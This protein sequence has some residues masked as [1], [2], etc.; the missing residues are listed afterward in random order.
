VIEWHKHSAESA[1]ENLGVSPL[2]GLSRDEAEERAGRYGLNEL[3]ERRLKSPWTILWE[4]L[5]STMDLILIFAAVVSFALGEWT[6]A[7]AILAIVAVN[8]LLGLR[9]EYKAEK[10]MAALKKMAVPTVRVRRSGSIQLISSRLL[11]PG[12][13]VLLDGGAR[14]PA[15]GRLIEAANLLVEEAALTGESLAVEKSATWLSERDVVL[16]DRINMVFMGTSVNQGRAVMLVTATGMQTE[17]GKIAEM[18]QGVDRSA[19]PLQLRLDRLGKVLAVAALLLVAVIFGLGLWREGTAH[20]R[21]LFLTAVSMAVAAVPEG[22][23]AVVTIA[24]ALG[25]Q[26]ML[27]RH[28]LV[29]K[30]LAVEALGSVSV[31]CSDKTG[32]LTENR[33]VVRTLIAGGTRYETPLPGGAEIPP[34]LF[35]ALMAG[36]L[37]NDAEVSID[38][39]TRTIHGDPTENALLNVAEEAGIRKAEWEGRWPRVAEI[40][41]DS[42]R[43][44]MTTLHRVGDAPTPAST[45]VA[46]S[47]PWLSF[48]KG[49]VDGLLTVCDRILLNGEVLPLDNEAAARVAD[50]NDL[51]AREGLRVLGFACAPWPDP[52]ENADAKRLEKGLVFIG[53]MALHDPPRREVKD[54]VA[55][56]RSAGIR[57]VMITGDHPLTA[58]HIASELG[59]LTHDG[60]V[61]TGNQLDEMDTAERNRTLVSATVFARVSPETKLAIVSALQAE[62]QIVAMTGDGV[63]DAPALKRANIGVAMGITGT[64]VSKEA[65]DIVLLDDNFATI[66]ATV[67]EGRTIYDNIRKFIKYLMTTNSAELWVML[68]APFL[69]MPLPLLPLQILWM[70]LVTDGL[71]ALALGVEPPERDVMRRPPV[72]AKESIFAGGTGFHILWVGL[73]MGLVSLALGWF[74]WRLEGMEG[75]EETR[76]QTMVF[77]ILTLSQMAHVL[78]IRTGMDSLFRVGLW[79]NR[80]LILAV[81]ATFAFQLILLYTPFFQQIFGLVPLTVVDLLVALV[82]GAVVF[83]AVEAEK[84]FYRSRRGIS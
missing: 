18:I 16:A 25:A 20:L 74:Y 9:Q 83:F 10:A 76:W 66:V 65:S 58:R 47:A 68:T 38:G 72:G 70:N 64:D 56:C 67:A 48:T 23:P 12:D 35:L 77:T 45:L 80:P 26:R 1:L 15:D 75:S 36:S 13:L 82:S 71:P 44:R 31:I 33:M 50:H 46:G 4:Q 60:Q 2:Q 73:L 7:F 37:C 84:W 3:N 21:E 32:T 19:T 63:N 57:P 51:L 49:A 29:R 62:G 34:E 17:L 55:L 8:A 78:A 42:E 52:I 43:K 30:L 59:I 69:G 41:F 6:D 61:V 5:T 39:A 79:S 53:L 54:A 40:P 14:V 22:L 27:S 28:A 11:V 81:L 24:L